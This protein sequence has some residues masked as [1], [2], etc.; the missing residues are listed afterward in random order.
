M[1]SDFGSEKKLTE[2]GVICAL[3]A[4]QHLF[5][6]TTRATNEVLET[7]R[8]AFD[9][10]SEVNIINQSALP[11]GWE[12]H[13]GKR[14]TRPKSNDANGRPSDLSQCVWLT[15]RFANNLY[16]VKFILSAW[17]AVDVI[18]GTEFINSHVE[19][20]MCREQKI[21][22]NNGSFPIVHQN[23]IIR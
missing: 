19:A 23:R 18:I 22:F 3:A 4:T 13:I 14:A 10:G 16:R 2:Y 6:G 9:T 12:H 11:P 15:V 8:F 7:A 5:D 21:R 1:K 17:T 20:I